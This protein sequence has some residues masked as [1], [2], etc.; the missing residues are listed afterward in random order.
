MSGMVPTPSPPQKICH[1]A[2]VNGTLFG[3]NGFGRCHSVKDLETRSRWV[4]W[5]G[6][7]R[8]GRD[9]QTQRR[10]PCEDRGRD[11]RDMQATSQGRQGFLAATR[12]WERGM[13]WI[14][15]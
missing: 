4:S 11:W 13:K 8:R 14:L 10:R 1:L 5:M 7:K 6:L 12:G 15:P 3:K 2:P 9:T